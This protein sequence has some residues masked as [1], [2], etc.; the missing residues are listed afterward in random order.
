MEATFSLCSNLDT[1]RL[2]KQVWQLPSLSLA[3][4]RHFAPC[5]H[6]RCISM[7]TIMFVHMAVLLCTWLYRS[8]KSWVCA[9]HIF[10]AL[11]V[12]TR[13]IKGY[14]RMK[15]LFIY[16]NITT[17]SNFHNR[18]P[19]MLF[20]LT[21]VMVALKARAIVATHRHVAELLLCLGPCIPAWLLSLDTHL[22][23]FVVFMSNYEQWSQY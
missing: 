8:D 16:S 18:V 15:N 4:T 23:T 1:T 7:T 12:R 17:S 2:L 9:E 6:A 5:A 14:V 13:T 20:S 21:I 19:V 3:C 22:E 11:Q 10:Y